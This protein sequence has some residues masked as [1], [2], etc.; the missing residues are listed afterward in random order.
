M[1]EDRP[2]VEMTPAIAEEQ[3]RVRRWA[4]LAAF[5]WSELKQYDEIPESVRGELAQTWLAQFLTW[6]ESE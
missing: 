2:R 4:L 3:E 1:N 6:E 5:V